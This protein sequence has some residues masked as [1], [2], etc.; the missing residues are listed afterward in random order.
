MTIPESFTWNNWY[1][2]RMAKWSNVHIH[3]H[4]TGNNWSGSASQNAMQSGLIAI[5]VQSYGAVFLETGNVSILKAL[6]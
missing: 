2:Y 5:P 3:T 1:R 6:E 4:Q